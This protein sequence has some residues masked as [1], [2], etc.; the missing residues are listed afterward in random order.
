MST[1]YKYP[2]VEISAHLDDD[3]AAADL[4]ANP[5]ETQ[6]SHIEKLM[7]NV[8]VAASGGG[9]KLRFQDT[10]GT[11]LGP[12][13]DVNGV[14]DFV[15]DFGEEPGLMGSSGVGIQAIVYGAA[16]GQ[17]SVYLHGVGHTSFGR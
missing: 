7:V 11:I 14:K 3:T 13:I 5:G 16:V 4:I 12:T 6:Y 10:V 17:A 15:L 1:K 8:L 9:G 2:Q